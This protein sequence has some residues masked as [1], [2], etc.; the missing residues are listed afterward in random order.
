MQWQGLQ[1][2]VGWTLR[3]LSSDCGGPALVASAEFCLLAAC[4]ERHASKLSASGGWLA[5]SSW[6]N[7]CPSPIFDALPFVL[8]RASFIVGHRILALI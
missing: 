7:S 5:V 1:A 3:P 2:A 8:G 6:P 4:V